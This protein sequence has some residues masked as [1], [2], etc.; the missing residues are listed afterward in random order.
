VL[1]QVASI[2][3][4]NIRETDLAGRFGGDEFMVILTN[5]DLNTAQAIAERIRLVVEDAVFIDGLRVT[6]SGGVRQYNREAF[7]DFIHFADMNLYQAKSHG[8]NRIR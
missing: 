5:T 1:T 7:L 8:K 6:I 4:E 2:I 3:K